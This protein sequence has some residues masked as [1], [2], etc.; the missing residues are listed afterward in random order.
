L[1]LNELHEIATL[2]ITALCLRDAGALACQG[3]KHMPA[4][5]ADVVRSVRGETTRFA[6]EFENAFDVLL[7]QADAIVEDSKELGQETALELLKKCEN[8]MREL[9]NAEHITKANTDSLSAIAAEEGGELDANDLRKRFD[10]GVKRHIDQQSARGEAQYTDHAKY[11][12]LQR[13]RQRLTGGASAE[14]EEMEEDLMMTQETIVNIKCPVLQ[15]DMTEKGP[16]RPMTSGKCS[17]R[18]SYQGA[19]QYLKGGK[20]KPCPVTGCNVQF[21][22]SELKDDK[23]MARTIKRLGEMD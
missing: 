7:L 12:Q 1:I 11:V 4:G 10:V 22:M 19:Q 2:G 5:V 3:N 8:S 16:L 14:E 20:T 15:V 13:K 17:H 6:A 18:I 9:I 21:K 23:E